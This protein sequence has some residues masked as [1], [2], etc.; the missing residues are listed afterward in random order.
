MNFQGDRIR[1]GFRRG[2]KTKV[3]PLALHDETTAF[4]ARASPVRRALRLTALD[5]A[6][7]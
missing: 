5:R 6:A 1:E 7:A 2:G 3:A 4:G